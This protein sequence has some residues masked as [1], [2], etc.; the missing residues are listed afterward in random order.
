MCVNRAWNECIQILLWKEITW[1]FQVIVAFC[2]GNFLLQKIC[3]FP[4]DGFP[5]MCSSNFKD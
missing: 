4:T 1:M 3:D 2:F 5:Y